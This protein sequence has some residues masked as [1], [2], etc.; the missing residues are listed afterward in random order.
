M[1]PPDQLVFG[2]YWDGRAAVFADPFRARRRLAQALQG[3]PQVWVDRYNDPA[4]PQHHEAV[5]FVLKAARW[6][7][8][9][10]PFDPAT[11][12]GATED[13]VEAVLRQFLEYQSEGKTRAAC[14]P[15]SWQPT[16]PQ[17]SEV[18]RFPTPRSSSSG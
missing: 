3:E 1:T 16:A 6:A 13:H 9:M 15:T 14:S 18:A 7:L 17:S 2:P 10:A 8:D 12:A 11:G 5:D 4:D